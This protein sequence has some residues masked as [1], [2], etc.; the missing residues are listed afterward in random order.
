MP[1]LTSKNYHTKAN[2]YLSTSMIKVFMASKERFKE[3]YIDRTFVREPSP[4][5]MLG[6]M[7][8]MIAT[9]SMRKFKMNYTPSV[10]KKDNPVLFEKQKDCRRQ[11]VTQVQ[12]D[13]AMRM[14]DSLLQ[15]EAFQ[16][17][18]DHQTQIVLT[19]NQ[20]MSH[21][22]LGLCGMLDFLYVDEAKKIAIITDL[23]TSASFGIPDKYYYKALDY[24]YF[25]QMAMYQLLVHVNFN[26]PI[27]NIECRHI[28]VINDP[29]NIHPVY[30]Y[31]FSDEI[32][33]ASA[34]ILSMQIAKLNIEIDFKRDDVSW[35]DSII[36][37][38][39]KDEY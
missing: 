2:K 27:A 4:S 34:D 3:Q 19:H 13:T 12:Y 30:T 14:A 25:L 15:T 21:S 10:F 36:L 6:S 32:L 39:L 26:I 28:V 8:D 16:D 24:G 35:E 9:E 20:S 38:E 11:V 31:K 37:G 29:D 23:K 7:V 5:M 1:K 18:K 17:I 33:S 22:L